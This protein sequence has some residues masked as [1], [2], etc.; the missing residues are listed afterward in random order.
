MNKKRLLS[1]LAGFGLLGLVLS[2]IASAETATSTVA[3]LQEL[4]KQLQDQIKTLQAQMEVLKQARQDVQE[5]VSLIRQL[6]IGMAGDDI[7]ALQIA[8]AADFDIYPE[9]LITG[10]FGPLTFQAV[11]RFQKKWGIEQVGRVGPKTLSKVNKVL[12]ENPI[13]MEENEDGDKSPCAIVPPG[14]LI[15]PGWLRKN[16]I[17]P[18]VPECQVVP[19]GIAK[20]LGII[21]ILTPTPTPDVTPPIISSVA[22]SNIASTTATVAWATN[23]AAKSKIYYSATT[24]LVFSAALNIANNSLVTSHSLGLTGLTASTTYYYVVESKDASNNT[25]TSTENSFETTLE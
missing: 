4:I 8:L 3:Q 25:A 2:P 9:G 10:Y 16:L 12:D 24:P 13:V 17:K 14:H 6:S 7:K 15:A 19:P 20:K 1:F 23:E 22:V 11:K 18:I 5:T 21:P